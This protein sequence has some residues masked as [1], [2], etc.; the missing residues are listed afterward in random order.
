MRRVLVGLIVVLVVVG[1]Y[2]L[3]VPNISGRPN[4]RLIEGVKSLVGSPSA[5]LPVP[6]FPGREAATRQ[7]TEGMF[8][9]MTL[10]CVW[11]IVRITVP[12]H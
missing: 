6:A 3:P 8:G 12:G 9:M 4:E 7:I 11:G 10:L 2:V 1:A 5:G